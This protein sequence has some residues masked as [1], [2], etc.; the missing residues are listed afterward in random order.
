MGV[1]YKAEDTKLKRTVALKF[2]PPDLTRDRDAK[3]RFIH[4]AQ[5]ASALQH[6]NI[7]TIHEIG[8]TENGQLFICMDC[9]EGETLKDRIARKPLPDNEATGIA[10]QVAAGLAK[11]HERG[12]VHRDMKPANIMVT[13]DGV[14]KILDFGLAKLVGRTR[15][16]KTGTTVGT[17]AYMSPEQTRGEEVDHRSDIWS[18][19]IVL[20]ELLTGQAPFKG[21]H[22]VAVV[23]SIMNEEPEPVTALRTGVPLELER[24][25]HKALSKDPNERY[26][27]VEDMRV[28]L[29]NLQRSMAISPKTASTGSTA[30][31]SRIGS[32]RVA[33]LLLIVLVVFVAVWLFPRVVGKDGG[34]P[35]KPP[36]R[37]G[38][39]LDERQASIA[40]RIK[41]FSRF[42]TRRL[43]FSYIL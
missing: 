14:V 24:I 27:H 2:L 15:V 16:T 7:C 33:G 21:D 42:L 5:A 3:T 30:R 40:R 36:A 37:S 38:S 28:D 20:Y 4:E 22:E 41:I 19:G 39:L 9:Y 43:F 31:A 6:N 1:L 12:M 29:G 13:S 11:E 26:Q 10:I 17:V 34:E 32:K 25:T 23:Y 8:E 18:L 35:G